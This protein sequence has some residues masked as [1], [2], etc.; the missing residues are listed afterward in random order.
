M[1]VLLVNPPLRTNE[2]SSLYPDGICYV[3][4]YLREHG[5]KVQVLDINGYRWTKAQFIE[6][7]RRQRFDA[8]GIGGLVTAFNHV[9]WISATVTNLFPNVPIFAGNTVASTIPEVLLKHSCVDVAVIGEGEVTALDLV[10]TLEING[11]L[12]NV[13]GIWY[14]TPSG[15]SIENPRREPITNLDSLPLPAFDLVPMEF[16]LRNFEKQYGFRGANLSTVRGCPFNCRF[17]CRGF[18][19]YKVRCRS[20]EN[21]VAELKVWIQ[22]YHVKGILFCDDLFIYNRK[23][24]FD[25]CDLLVKEK[26]DYLKW[27]VSARV[28]LLTL[29][30]AKKMKE[31]GCLWLQFGFESHSP[32][33]LEYYNKR[34][35]VEDQQRAIDICRKV[36]LGWHG[37]YIIGAANEDEG[38]LQ[39]TFEFTRRNGLDFKPDNLLMPLPQTP[40][41]EECKQRRLIKDEFEY[42][43][44][45]ADAGD[46]DK[47]VLNVTNNFSDEELLHIFH[48]YRHYDQTMSKRL[49]L[50]AKNPSHVVSKIKE[51][52]VQYCVNTLFKG[53]LL[54]RDLQRVEELRFQSRNEWT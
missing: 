3:A 14:K 34:N 40:I 43:K 51:R 37:S 39:E 46:A 32:K 17:C 30:L 18:I 29:E 35:T 36:G 12:A 23:R 50:I 21:I 47:L 13:K 20:P 42:V 26:L 4:S 27:I 16:Y 2:P 1:K 11:N 8:V 49:V 38:T 19:G 54:Q 7:L 9:Q 33:V 22:K 41:Y 44:S 15:L 53:V 6:V 45:L 52:G 31:T 5:H 28:E 10:N 24:V 48:N 25:F